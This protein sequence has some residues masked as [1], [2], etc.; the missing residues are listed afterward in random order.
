M[1][2]ILEFGNMHSVFYWRVEMIR[3]HR[4]S[5]PGQMFSYV[6]VRLAADVNGKRLLVVVFDTPFIF[7]CGP[8][9]LYRPLPQK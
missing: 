8:Q 5:V 6:N 4:H 2:M 7:I 9:P 3:R 1:C